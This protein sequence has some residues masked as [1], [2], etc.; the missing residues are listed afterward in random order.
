MRLRALVSVPVILLFG[1]IHTAGVAQEL[2]VPLRV[3]QRRV[4]VSDASV[5]GKPDVIV[6]ARVIQKCEAE[7]QGDVAMIP[8]EIGTIFRYFMAHY[9]EPVRVNK[10]AA[11]DPDLAMVKFYFR[12]PLEGPAALPLSLGHTYVLLLDA[13]QYFPPGPDYTIAHPQVGFEI[14][15]ASGQRRVRPIIR[16][17]ELDRF[18][19]QRLDD[20]LTEIRRQAK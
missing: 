14:V 8:K 6:M 19:G 9:T 17:G 4:A 2:S 7:Q 13:I 18:D 11:G 20:V 10:R 3:V 12:A 5:F 1:S 16:G 15:E